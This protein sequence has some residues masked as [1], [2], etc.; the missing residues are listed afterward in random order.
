[1]FTNTI[2]EKYMDNFNWLKEIANINEKHWHQD[3]VIRYWDIPNHEFYDKE[4]R[5]TAYIKPPDIKGIDYA[6]AYNCSSDITW[7]EILNRL[8]RFKDV[9]TKNSSRE[10][11]IN[12]AHNDYNENKAV[13]KYGETLITI[14][15]QHR[16]ALAK[17]LEIPSIQVYVAEKVFNHER[18]SRFLK[19]QEHVNCFKRL[20]F[21]DDNFTVNYQNCIQCRLVSRCL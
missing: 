10:E 11:L 1:M 4:K 18:Y 19:R 21:L 16:L 3:N 17:F 7:L 2:Y 15:G 13:M 5:Y 14:T 12:H 8:K 9:R 6:Y 20:G